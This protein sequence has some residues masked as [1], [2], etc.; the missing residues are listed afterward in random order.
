MRKSWNRDPQ[1]AP[2]LTSIGFG[3]APLVALRDLKIAAI[4][5][6]APQFSTDEIEEDLILITQG[7]VRGFVRDEDLN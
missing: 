3:D 1:G 4:I 7:G 6:G 5:Q 2:I